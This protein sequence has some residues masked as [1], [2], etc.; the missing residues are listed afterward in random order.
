[1]Y[2]FHNSLCVY[3]I[4][5]QVDIAERLVFQWNVRHS[6]VAILTPYT[7]QKEAISD[8]VKRRREFQRRIERRGDITIKS[9]TES[10]GKVL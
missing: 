9:I 10:Q 1:M 3:T 5:I 8:E 7:A 2:A 6:E 4:L